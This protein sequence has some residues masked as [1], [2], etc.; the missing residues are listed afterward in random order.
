MRRSLRAV[1]AALLIV[2]AISPADAAPKRPLGAEVEFWAGQNL[3]PCA[4]S[5]DP[6][7]CPR[8]LSVFSDDVWAALAKHGGVLFLNLV[9]GAD[10]GPGATRK[11]AIP[12]LRRANRLSVPVGAWITVPVDGGTFADE[13]NAPL[14]DAAVRALPAWLAKHRVRVRE[15]VLDLEQPVGTQ[16]VAELM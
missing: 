15:I 7:Y 2:P 11:D 10:Y 5:A 9:Y 16:P 1:V 4:G 12:L 3:Q 14:M 8:D 13:N 6:A